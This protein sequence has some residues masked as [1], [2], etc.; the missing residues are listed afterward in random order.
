MRSPEML[1][2]RRESAGGAGFYFSGP[3]VTRGPARM[4]GSSWQRRRAASPSPACPEGSIPSRS[5][6]EEGGGRA[7]AAAPKA[8]PPCVPARLD[9]TRRR[10]RVS[11]PPT[12]RVQWGSGPTP[13]AVWRRCGTRQGV[14]RA[15]PSRV[16]AEAPV[17]PAPTGRCA[18]A[19][20]RR[21]VHP[22]PPPHG[23]SPGECGTMSDGVCEGR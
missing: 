1:R 15:H 12:P 17:R 5:V 4:H 20:M 21:R 14:R 22:A 16:A 10:V 13:P 19:A 9:A 23:P 11:P 2:L 7:A 18:A 8:A 6:G 3:T